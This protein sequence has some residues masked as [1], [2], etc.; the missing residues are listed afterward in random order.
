MADLTGEV[1]RRYVADLFSRISRRYDLMNTLMTFG[2][3]RR[4]RRLAAL[5]AMEGLEGLALDVGTGTGD[6][7]LALNR[8]EGTTRVVGLDLLEA[9]TTL[10]F[11]KSQSAHC[12]N[13]VQFLVGDALSL[14]FP[15]DTFVCVT[16]AFSLRN[17][18]NLEGSLREMVR[19]ARP[20]GRILSLET[21]PV[22]KGPLRP[23]VR[24]YFRKVVPLLGS[25][26]AADRAAYTYLPQSVD[27]FLSSQRL[28][29]LFKEV[30]L[31]EVH[32]QSLALGSV[33]LHWGTKDS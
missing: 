28:S 1:K 13:K 7:A 21:L 3:D 4:W 2:M 31:K 5:K 22:D 12:T 9:M 16:S 19:V 27:W 15:D 6:L 11:G 20:G 17:M 18:P 8:V 30:G 26:I 33:H 10:A 29:Q 14:P 25:L 23:A 24:F 32:Q